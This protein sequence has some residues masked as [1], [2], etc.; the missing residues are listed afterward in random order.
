MTLD[1]EQSR[2]AWHA[3]LMTALS[4]AIEHLQVLIFDEGWDELRAAAGSDE[5][6]LRDSVATY[7]RELAR[8]FSFVRTSGALPDAVAWSTLKAD[9]RRSALDAATEISLRTALESGLY[10]AEPVEMGDHAVYLGWSA[11]LRA[12]L[13]S[14]VRAELPPP[15]AD[16]AEEDRLQWA[17]DTLA[18][19]EDHEAFNDAFRTWISVNNADRSDVG[20]IVSLQ[21]RLMA[22]PRFDLVL[23]TSLRWLATALPG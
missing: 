1:D 3:A 16:D 4:D 14:N 8:V 10:A 23:N 2:Q 20:G 22:L 7:E 11:A 6:A 17:Y 18:P 5:A 19:L 15:A 9:L 13:A 21:D 12:F